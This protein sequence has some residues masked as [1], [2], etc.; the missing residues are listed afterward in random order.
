MPT[1]SPIER[2]DLERK[3]IFRELQEAAAKQLADYLPVPLSDSVVVN[4][5][6]DPVVELDKRLGK[7][8][9]GIIVELT[10]IEPAGDDDDEVSA[11]LLIHVEEKF[12]TNHSATGTKISAF[13]AAVLCWTA[14]KD[15]APPDP[16]APIKFLGL[17]LGAEGGGQVLWDLSISSDTHVQPV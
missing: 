16:W 3:S 9:L 5:E 7:T 12:I 1:L 14:F 10:D 4:V 15:W 17:N 2:L 13:D 8:G 11:A 6:A